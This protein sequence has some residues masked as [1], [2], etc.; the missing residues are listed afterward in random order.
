M[1]TESAKIIIDAEDL[2]SKKF[3]Q[4]ARNAEK[5]IKAVKET[6]KQAKSSTEFFGTLA[7]TLGGTALSGYASQLAGLTEK[8]SQ[9]AEVSKLGTAGTLAFKAGLLGVV[10]VITYQVTTSIANLIYQTKALERA[11]DSAFESRLESMNSLRSA[12]QR[13]FSQQM[14]DLDLR[15]QL[16][17]PGIDVRGEKERM[18]GELRDN[19]QQTGN[20]I[21]EAKKAIE[22]YEQ[23][24]VKLDPV[25]AAFIEAEKQ[26]IAAMKASMD[27]MRAQQDVLRD[28]LSERARVND[29]IRKQIELEKEAERAKQQAAEAERR[30][31]ERLADLLQKENDR[32]EQQRIELEKGGEAARAF[33]LEKQGLSRADAER[34][35]A[36][37]TAIDEMKARDRT[38]TLG[39]QALESRLLTRGPMEKAAE[40]QVRL[41]EQI[42]DKLPLTSSPSSKL[43]V[44]VVG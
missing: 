43:E 14:E 2:A 9:F 3:E 21:A 40:K 16:Q 18:L 6:G 13:A 31:K 5:N 1:T 44:R 15:S 34:L 23:Q 4:A 25:Q 10:G 41:L 36:E 42:R 26:R 38:T 32:L 20:E 12:Q 27:Q 37:Q 8:T 28:D 39:T 35:A 33:A 24:W 17:D 30:E 7:N 11:L 22:E 29:E 19:I